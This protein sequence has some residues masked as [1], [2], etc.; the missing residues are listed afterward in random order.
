MKKII[1]I[2]IDV[3]I[4]A[5]VV[6]WGVVLFKEFASFGDQTAQLVFNKFNIKVILFGLFV[7]TAV[8]IA[9][10]LNLILDKTLPQESAPIVKPKHSLDSLSVNAMGDSED[11]IGSLELLRTLLSSNLT[12]IER[13]GDNLSATGA[14]STQE[15]LSEEFMLKMLVSQSKLNDVKSLAELLDT[16]VMTA[17]ELTASKRVSLLLYNPGTKKLSMTRSIGIDVKEKIEIGTSEG[18]A[19]YAYKNSK[20]IYVTNIESHPEFGRENKPQYRSKSFVIFPIKVFSG[21]TVGVLNLTEKDSE[22][23]VFDMIDLEK[24]NMV[25]NAFS[26]KIGNMIL[27]TEFTKEGKTTEDLKKLI[28]QFLM[29]V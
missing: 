26:L 21:V 4:V 22:S 14:P 3:I 6:V 1:T 28:L 9:F 29:K 11:I 20:R 27:S 17:S 13:L 23:G 18:V 10:Y 5:I 16:I 24:L 7:I 8:T 15:S 2:V 19:G 25:I 12:A